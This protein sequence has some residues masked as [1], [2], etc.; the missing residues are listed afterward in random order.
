MK[1]KRCPFCLSL[2][3]EL[4]SKSRK[5]GEF[6]RFIGREEAVICNQCGA[7]GPKAFED[8]DDCEKLWNNRQKRQK[9]S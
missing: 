7:S 9:K 6:G 5:F 4:K 1:L 3:V 8:Y 2:N